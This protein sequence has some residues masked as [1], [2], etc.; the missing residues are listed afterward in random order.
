MNHNYEKYR[1][2]FTSSKLLVIGGKNAEQNEEILKEIIS[3]KEEIILMHTS[4]PGSPFCAI[5]SN[6]EKIKNKDIKEA[7]IFT[8]CFSKAWKEGK[9][10]TTIDIFNNKQLF[11][12]EKMKAGTWG[13]LGKVKKIKVPLELILTIQNGKLRAVPRIT[14]KDKK[15]AIL[16]IVPGKIPKEEIA[17]KIYEVLG[18]KFKNEEILS[19]LPAGGIKII[20]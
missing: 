4:D 9:K 5:L 6:K 13:V 17:K 20:K 11:K 12:E 3:A 18:N 19:A 7:A 16:K 1:W 2:F 15:E 14:I 10:E 8:A